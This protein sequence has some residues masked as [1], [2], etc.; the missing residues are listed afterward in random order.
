MWQQAYLLD[1]LV[2]KKSIRHF[3]QSKKVSGY[4]AHPKKDTL[5]LLIGAY[6]PLSPVL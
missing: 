3:R 6:H 2:L 5:L 1:L 4:S